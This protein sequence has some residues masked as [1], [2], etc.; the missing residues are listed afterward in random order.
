MDK[1]PNKEKLKG[2]RLKRRLG[3]IVSINQGDILVQVVDIRQS[4]VVL[5]FSSEKGKNSIVRF[6][7]E[8]R[9][10]KEDLS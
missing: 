1:L 10:K 4:H 6:E 7:V 2:L 3:E 8:G 5:A 9:M